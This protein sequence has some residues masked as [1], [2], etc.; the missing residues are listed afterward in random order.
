[1]KKILFIT[2][3][4][5]TGE[6]IYPILPI[7]ASEYKIDLLKV[8]QMAN[9][10]K[11][12][13]DRDMRLK[14]DEDYLHLFD[15]VFLNTCDV[16]KYNLIISDDNRYTT[17][18]K[19]SNLYNQKKCSMV[20]FEHGNNNK[21]YFG[22][23]HNVV[24][25]K[26]FVFGDKDVKHRDQIAGGIPSND[27]LLQYAN[28]KKK[29]IMVIVN[30][31]GNRTSPFK[32]NFDEMLFN[33][34]QLINLQKQINLPVVIKLKSRADEGGFEKNLRYLQS[35]LPNELDY[36]IVIDAEDDNKLIAESVCVI[37]APS[38]LAFKPIQLGIPTVLIKDS[39]QTGSFYDFEGLFDIR[40]YDNNYLLSEHNYT[41]WISRSI[42]G[43]LQF[44]S[45]NVVVSKLKEII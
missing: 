17:K 4:Y 26:C 25:D 9:K 22:I 12:V 1:M 29:H 41:D 43:G 33:S 36:K 31:L 40:E 23:G 19:L 37:S 45:T 14:F 27:G 44:N 20:S 8:Y 39:G 24:F 2:S 34:L 7:L 3:Q 30:F 42:E 21:G 10:H 16:T 5:R 38:T 32:V 18:T 6:R 35:I 13:G 28:L 11:W 15:S